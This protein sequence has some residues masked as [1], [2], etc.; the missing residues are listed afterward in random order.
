MLIRHVSL[1]A[2]LCWGSLA[3]YGDAAN[4]AGYVF[5]LPGPNIAGAHFQGWGYNAN[6]FNPVFDGLGPTS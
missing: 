2:C 1:V 5:E 4:G 3:A 6:P